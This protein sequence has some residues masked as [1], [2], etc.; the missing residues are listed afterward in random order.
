MACLMWSPT[1]SAALRDYAWLSTWRSRYA[2][3]KTSHSFSAMLSPGQ[4]RG[5]APPKGPFQMR[6]LSF[7]QRPGRKA[8]GSSKA[9]GSTCASGMDAVTIVPA[10][11]S[12]LPRRKGRRVDSG[13]TELQGHKDL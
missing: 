6:Y 10:G 4:W 5:A 1:T 7:G 3:V 11:K 12:R 9:D 13:S 2:V 8:I